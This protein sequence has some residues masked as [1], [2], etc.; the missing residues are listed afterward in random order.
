MSA[1]IRTRSVLSFFAAAVF[2]AACSETDGPT[3][4]VT[5]RF[6]KAP[7]G[8]LTV[9]A[10]SPSASPKNTT[11]DV[12]ITGTGFVTGST[13][14][15]LLG[16]LPDSRVRTNSTRFVSSTS[17]VANITI[18]AD[19][20]PSRYDVAVATPQG[21]KGIGTE[22]FTVLP[23]QQ[24]V[25]PSGTSNATGIN[26]SGV[27]AGY[28]SGGC[29]AGTI[30]SIWMDVATRIDLPLP[31]GYCRGVAT[32]VNNN[33]D[34]LGRV[35]Q[36]GSS[37]GRIVRWVHGA[38][39]YVPI[40]VGSIGAVGQLLGGFNNSGHA[41]FHQSGGV[42]PGQIRSA[43]WWSEATGAIVLAFPAGHIICVAEDLN[44]LDQIVGECEDS[45]SFMPV[46]WDSPSA[47]PSIL[48]TLAGYNYGGTVRSINNSGVAVGTVLNRAKSGKITETGVRWTRTQ[49]GWQ[50]SVLPDLGGGQSLP[51]SVND[52]GWIVG[53]SSVAASQYVAALWDPALAVKNLGGFG[54]NGIAHQITPGGVVPMR[55]VGQSAVGGDN[56]AVV[57]NLSQ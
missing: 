8:G 53:R 51:L 15:W 35:D 12:Q 17:L 54:P 39:G 36:A 27:M 24:L 7:A 38:E 10:A 32:K 42:A 1:P 11:V 46:I 5:P 3:A 56:R 48:P 14:E 57:W 16:G 25:T 18:S 26:S 37:A 52:D 23:M 29:D 34:V 30:P 21:K 43:I 40:L 13:A 47:A 45:Q 2:V 4:L 28:R 49:S 22:K 41:A 6:A 31:V 20:V 19:A 9:Q 44:D 33:G 50:V 55:I